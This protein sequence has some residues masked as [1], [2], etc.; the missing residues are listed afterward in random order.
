MQIKVI[1]TALEDFGRMFKVRRMNYNEII[2]N[3]PTGNGLKYFSFNDVEC[4]RE[5]EIDD[6]LIDNRDFLKIKLKRG[7]SVVLYSAIYDSIKDEIEDEIESLNVLR[8]KYKINKRGIWDKEILVCVN[9]KFAL[10]IQASGQNFK[11]DGYNIIVNKV[12]KDIFL[13][14]CKNEIENIE[15]EIELKMKVIDSFKEAIDDVKKAHEY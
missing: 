3:Y 1:N 5:N 12:E 15:K 11:R 7:V 2:V 9:N 10:E 4:I 6:F 13:E 14:Q 8:D